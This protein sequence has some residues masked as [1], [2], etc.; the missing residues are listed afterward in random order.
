MAIIHKHFELKA[1]DASAVAERSA[2]PQM[3][4]LARSAPPSLR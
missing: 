4:A 2:I 3:P 1:I